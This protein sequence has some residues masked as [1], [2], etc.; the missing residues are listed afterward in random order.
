[1]EVRMPDLEYIFHPG[2]IAVVGASPN[3]GR[4][5]AFLGSLI[6]FNYK[7][8][9]YPIHPKAGEVSGLKAYPS[10]LDIPG[11]VDHV[12]CLIRADLTPQLMRECVAKKVRLVQFFTAG[13]SETG[14][15]EGIRLEREIVEIARRGNVRAL[16]PN[17]MG[18]Y[19]PS[20]GISYQP[21]FPKESG[22]VG[23]LS[24][25]GGNSMDLVMLGA[26]RGVRF[27]KVVS[28]GNACDINEADLMEYFADDP[29]TKI[30]IGYIEGTRDGRRLVQALQKAADAKPVI[31]LKGGRTEAGTKAAASHTGA[32]AG[33][34]VIWESLFR[35][36]GIMQVD[37]MDE[38]I[39][40]VL[41][42]QHSN[43]LMG[44]KIGLIGIGGGSSVLITDNCAEE[45]L[46][47]PSFPDELRRGLREIIPKE[48]DPGTTVRNPIDLSVL[49]WN[50]DILS[51]ALQAVAAYNEIDSILVHFGLHAGALNPRFRKSIAADVDALIKTKRNLNKPLVMV[52][53]D[54]HVS[55]VTKF[56]SEIQE[57]CRQADIPVFPSFNR[58]ARAMSR[59]VQYY[60]R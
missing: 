52:L 59:F 24:Q 7:G 58:A 5:T 8:K 23:F 36:L 42:F 25:S 19:Y 22:C 34:N 32:L 37:D 1:M 41:L 2:S 27:S 46:I 15:E 4:T 31:M 38:L 16:G 13:F 3:S 53:H 49:G 10:I 39:D 14:E 60:E 47:V 6:Q 55:E 54:D 26:A 51:K 18:I 48:V 12:T 9:L 50:P 40:L 28:F 45:G 44:R 20:L 29:E 56:S 11:P 30:I 35:Q 43:P 17:C 57:R 21:F 33:S